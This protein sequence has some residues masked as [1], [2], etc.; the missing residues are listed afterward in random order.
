MSRRL[1][2]QHLLL[3]ALGAEVRDVEALDDAVAG[4]VVDE[5]DLRDDRRR[6]LDE[7]RARAV[8]LE[9]A[10]SQLTQSRT[11]HELMRSISPR[12]MTAVPRRDLVDQIA[13]LVVLVDDAA[14]LHVADVVPLVNGGLKLGFMFARF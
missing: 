3:V 10:T 1:D 2:E 12:S 13:E 11:P 8:L 9:L 5:V 4:E 14:E 7:H 6:A